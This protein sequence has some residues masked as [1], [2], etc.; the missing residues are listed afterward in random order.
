MTACVCLAYVMAGAQ[1]SW[2]HCW[3]HWALLQHL[4]MGHRRSVTFTKARKSVPDQ[5][6]NHKE[7]IKLL[8]CLIL[9]CH[10]WQQSKGL[11]LTPL[12]HRSLW[13]SLT[14]FTTSSVPS[15]YTDYTSR[16]SCIHCT[17]CDFFLHS[18]QCHLG[19]FILILALWLLLLIENI[20][21]FHF[22]LFTVFPPPN[23]YSQRDLGTQIHFELIGIV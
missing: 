16:E 18:N 10:F 11:I 13:F 5:E 8:F 14:L 22:C 7:E 15:S 2:N 12:P 19:W 21:F 4:Q 3:T 20:H 1:A 9:R 6:R 23:E 17:D